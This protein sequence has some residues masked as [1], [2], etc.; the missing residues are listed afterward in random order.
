LTRVR[1]LLDILITAVEDAP[2][3]VIVQ[4]AGDGSEQLL[5]FR[6]LLEESFRV[7]GGLRAAGLEPGT[8][9]IMLPGSST[10]FLP[11]WGAVVAGLLPVPLAPVPDKVW[12]V[13]AHLGRPPV[14]VSAEL[15]RLAGQFA[16]AATAPMGRLLTLEEL[17]RADPISNLHQPTPEDVAF[18][19]FP[20][21]ARA[22]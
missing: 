2:D 6:R 9:V 1:T 20:P 12:A 21:A 3:Q 19:Q 11:F 22:R 14:L 5:T 15:D 4:V 7:A 18:L 13:W 10:D 8:P 17:R 16:G